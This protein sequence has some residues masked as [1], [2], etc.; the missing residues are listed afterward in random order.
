MLRKILLNV[1]MG[2]TGCL[3]ITGCAATRPQAT[4]AGGRAG[5]Q[6]TLPEARPL[7]AQYR[8]ADREVR[9]GATEMSDRAA[10][11][12]G[13]L[14]LID[15]LSAA[16][17]QS[18][19]LV[20]FSYEVRAGEARILQAG[21]LPNPEL[22]F[23]VEEYDRDGEGFDSAE[24]ALVLGQLFEL[25]GKRRWRKRI[26]EA[27]G[28]LAGWDFESKRLDVF[29]ETAK[30]FTAVIATQKRL[31]L[32]GSAV[33]L[34]EKTSSAVGERVKAGK[35]PPLQASKSEAELEMARMEAREAENA[36]GIARKRL[37]AMWGAE[38][39]SFGDVE[40]SL[41]AILDAIPPLEALRS[42]LSL[43]PDLARW[44]VELRLRRAVV[45]SEKA[46][47][48]P[49]MAASVGY[50]QYEEDGT[51]ALAFG[52]GLPLP[53]FDRNQGNIAAATHELSKAEAERSA[54]ELALATELGETHAAL[55]AA[56]QR[57]ATLQGKV[58]PVMEGAFEA[59]HEG[60]RQGKFGFLDMLDAQRG[61]FEAK[62]ALVDALSG[63][64]SALIDV[65]RITGTSI[66]E[67]MNNK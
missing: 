23:G 37:A 56:H 15:A 58:V 8:T 42:R 13:T 33:E 2:G 26:A 30:R 36:L 59:A 44:E 32:A 63:Y 35:E 46:A 20:A 31:E 39:V 18:P 21:V 34:A 22:E 14:R 1:M 43:N 54:A 61:L 29:T 27:E 60:Y 52:V 55:T 24:T 53:L 17:L 41:D 4:Q 28:E 11:P 48:V 12:T 19:E 5:Q 7:G 65:Q 40:G 25:G 66:E 6:I 64:H 47:R 50:L 62:G 3:L 49:D 51:D 9:P 45:S 16:L 57:V 38:R 67:L 10:E